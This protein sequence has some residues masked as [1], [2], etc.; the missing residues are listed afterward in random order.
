MWYVECISRVCKVPLLY[1]AS[2]PHWWCVRVTRSVHV[3]HVVHVK[4]K[5]IQ[6]TQHV[7]PPWRE[8]AELPTPYPTHV[9]RQATPGSDHPN[10][11]ASDITRDP[12]LEL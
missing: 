10:T 1:T 2:P 5:F 6:Q 4:K 3:V 7:F 12:E 8:H 9:L 11:L